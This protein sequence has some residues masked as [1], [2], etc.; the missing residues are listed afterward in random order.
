MKALF[1]LKITL[2]LGR[3]QCCNQITGTDPDDLLNFAA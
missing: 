2:F 1:N 3:E